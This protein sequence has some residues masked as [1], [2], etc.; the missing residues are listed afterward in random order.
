MSK[1]DIIGKLFE[2]VDFQLLGDGTWL[3]NREVATSFRKTLR[4]LGLEEDVPE[5]PGN[6][7]ST[8]LGSEL[9]LD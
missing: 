1:A 2:V 6:T 5:T 4:D 8:A 7:R 9:N 3:A